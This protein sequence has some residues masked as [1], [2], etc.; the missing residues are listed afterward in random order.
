MKKLVS[1]FIIVSSFLVA[2]GGDSN[3]E[4]NDSTNNNQE[5]NSNCIDFA[6][7]EKYNSLDPIHITDVA[8]FHIGSQIFEPLLRFDEKDLSI[9]PLLAESW[10]VDE[11]NLTHTFTLK[12]GVFFQDN[13]CFEGGKGREVKASD[14]LYSFK[15]IFSKPN[16]YAYS[17][18]KG[19]IAGSEEFKNNGGEI[20]GISVVDDYTITF[21]LNEPSSNFMGLL[22][23]MSTSIVAKEAIEN[24]VAVGTGPFMY[25]KEMDTEKAVTLSKNN[26]YH[27]KG[28]PHIE[29]VAFNYVKSGQE[30]LDWF[31]AGKL[32]VITGLPSKSI[33]EI[34]EEK[35]ADFQKHPVKYVLERYPQAATTY[36]NLNT[37]KE[38]FNDI[39][40]R[41]A[42]SMAINKNKI[43]DNILKGEAAG[44]GDHGIVSAAINKYDYS[45]VIGYEFDAS[46]AKQL[47]KEAGYENGK[48]FPNLILAAGK[49][50]TSLRIA[51]E[52]QKQLLSNLNIN[53][54][55]SSVTVAEKNDMNAK[56]E[57]HMSLNGWL[58]EYP[59][60]TSF[61]SLFYGKNV[62][63]SMEESSF[64]NESR[65]KNDAFDKL[66]EEALITLDDAKRY[67][68][69]LSADQIIASEVP[70][71]PLWYHE[72]Y[73]LIQSS[74]KGYKPNPM[75]IQYLV[76]VKIE[77]N[78]LQ[79]EKG[80]EK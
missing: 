70:G 46:K 26:N 60:P 37:A 73:L 15:R 56:S 20:S 22:A 53:I 57:C 77:P 5:V 13:N 39:K 62:A 35:I 80:K 54:E 9:K 27:I 79:A 55:I 12:K 38:P 48:G 2:C 10:D 74:V 8:S 21:K 18:L 7:T 76:D 65:F 59:D 42:I 24:K 61:L 72:D 33:K 49:G 31:M 25:N 78:N 41:K 47:L 19:K 4:N 64:P 36:L 28:K 11:S 52:I 14:V 23:T 1:I 40:V 63:E 3:V 44:P 17:L 29:C 75:N 58:A 50:N 71:I 67:E 34:V 32:D 6:I 30:Q 69:C 45:S 66:Y 51:F 16:N 43:V 68:L